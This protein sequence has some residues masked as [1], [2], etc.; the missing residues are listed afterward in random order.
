M[1]SKERELLTEELGLYYVSEWLENS[2]CLRILE[3]FL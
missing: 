2:D 1:L 3:L